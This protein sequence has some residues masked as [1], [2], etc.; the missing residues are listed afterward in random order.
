VESLTFAINSYGSFFGQSAFAQHA[1]VNENS[2]VKVPSDT[3]LVSLAP[4]GC[5]LQTGA[6]AVLNFLKPAKSTS[7]LVVGIGAVGCG[8][9]FAAKYLGLETIIAVDL[10]DEKLALA[11]DLGATHTF[12]ARDPEIVQKIK[13]LTKYDMGTTYAVEC[14]GNVRAIMMAWEALANKGHLVS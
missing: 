8:A 12:N 7:I 2:I 11:K 1:I 6:G 14:S 10:V 4:L 3:D 13:A 5:G 9:L